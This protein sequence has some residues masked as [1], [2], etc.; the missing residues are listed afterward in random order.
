MLSK[1]F[2]TVFLSG[3]RIPASTATEGGTGGRLITYIYTVF[4]YSI[5]SSRQC[6]AVLPPVIWEIGAFEYM[7][8]GWILLEFV[9]TKITVFVGP[10]TEAGVGTL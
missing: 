8:L 9:N 7:V 4:P 2:L 6:S 10:A 1:G 5:R 3:H